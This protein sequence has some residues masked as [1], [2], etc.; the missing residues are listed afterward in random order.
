MH[1]ILLKKRF[2]EL[3]QT[4]KKSIYD[5]TKQINCE[6]KKEKNIFVWHTAS[7]DYKHHGE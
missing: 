4:I 2:S 1:V 7:W 3:P 6:N 5:F